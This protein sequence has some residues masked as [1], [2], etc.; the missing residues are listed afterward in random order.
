MGK[1]APLLIGL[2]ATDVKAAINHS[3]GLAIFYAVAGIFGL[4][5]FGALLV[6]AGY[7]LTRTMS[8]D[9]AAL[10]IAAVLMA[11][12][13]VMLAVASIRS[14]RYK[15]RTHSGKA[16]K[17]L[18]AAAAV[19]FVPLL[20]SNR[21]GLGLLAAFAGYALANRRPRTVVKSDSERRYP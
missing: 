6:A 15:R 4:A 14:A 3:R 20:A 16:A 7:Y 19:S 18:A 13:A 9:A 17:T 1:L 10:L 2:L 11:I 5:G 12:S 8:P 21:A